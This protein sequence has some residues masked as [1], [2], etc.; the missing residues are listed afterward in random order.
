M[1]GVVVKA[2]GCYARDRD[3]TPDQGRAKI[4]EVPGA[5]KAPKIFNTDS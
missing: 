4:N 1:T 2:L 3:L 5:D